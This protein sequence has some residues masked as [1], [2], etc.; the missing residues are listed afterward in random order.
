MNSRDLLRIKKDFK[1]ILRDKDIYDAVIFGSFAKGKLNPQDIDVALIT[2]K[3]FKKVKDYHASIITLNDFFKPISL[4]NNLL[5]EGYSMKKNKPFSEVYGFR[6]RCLFRYELSGLS[7]SKKVQTVNFLRGKKG[8]AGLVEEKKGEWLS[9]QTFLSPV[10]YESI[11]EKFFINSK[12][13]F[14]KYYVLID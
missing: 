10:I 12:V 9:N 3:K 6:N 2:N 11:F 13:K 1:K 4:V 5:R 8:S 7:T 14:K